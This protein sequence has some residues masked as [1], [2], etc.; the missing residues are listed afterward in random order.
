[1]RANVG[2]LARICNGVG[3]DF[4]S[5]TTLHHPLNII[6]PTRV[7]KYHLLKVRMFQFGIHRHGKKVDHF[8]CFRAKEMGS[9]DLPCF[10]VYQ[11]FIRITLFIDPFGIEPVWHQFVLQ[12]KV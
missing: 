2:K 1:M 4:Q 7:R 11:S 9:K 6:P 8:R 3:V 5:V 10:I 12:G